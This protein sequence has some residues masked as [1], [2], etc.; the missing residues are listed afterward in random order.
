MRENLLVLV[1]TYADARGWQLATVSNKI[2]GHY[3]FLADF[4]AG[5]TSCR[6]DTYYRMI[7]EL[8]DL[9]PS[10]L[11]WPRTVAIPHPSRYPR[12][13]KRRPRSGKFLGKKP[14]KKAAR[15]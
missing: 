14:S 12:P 6:I 3:R 10:G 9:W 1:Q 7:D 11:R 15:G 5:R 2:H 4:F 13:G 8:R